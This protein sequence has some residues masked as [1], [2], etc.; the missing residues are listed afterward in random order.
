[1][2]QLRISL[3]FRQTFDEARTIETIEKNYSISKVYEAMM[4]NIQTNQKNKLV[5]DKS[6]AL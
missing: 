2:R 1:M 3:I 5:S 6:V 4:L